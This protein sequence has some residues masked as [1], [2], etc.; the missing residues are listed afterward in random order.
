M[1]CRSPSETRRSTCV[2]LFTDVHSR[3]AAN[4]TNG[5]QREVVHSETP[6]RSHVVHTVV[7]MAR[8]PNFNVLMSMVTW[9]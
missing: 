3:T 7:P 1:T 9:S 6:S 2:V 4:D 5:G 8:Q